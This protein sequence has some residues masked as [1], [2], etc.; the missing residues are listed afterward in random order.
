MHECCVI[1][2]PNNETFK[3]FLTWLVDVRRSVIVVPFSISLVIPCVFVLSPKIF[4]YLMR[5]ISVERQPYSRSGE[6]LKI[7]PDYL[8]IHYESKTD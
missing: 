5:K 7:I 1:L 4:I 8:E 3:Q 2:D 6:H